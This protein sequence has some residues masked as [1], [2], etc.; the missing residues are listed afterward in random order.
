MGARGGRRSRSC[1]E[2]SILWGNFSPNPAPFLGHV[3]AVT[4]QVPGCRHAAGWHAGECRGAAERPPARGFSWSPLAGP[5]L[6]W[7]SI[8]PFPA[9]TVECKGPA[10][11]GCRR[12]RPRQ[13]CPASPGDVLQMLPLR[14]RKPLML[15]GSGVSGQGERSPPLSGQPHLL[16]APAVKAVFACRALAS[17]PRLDWA[18]GNGPQ[19]SLPSARPLTQRRACWCPLQPAA[20]LVPLTCSALRAAAPPGRLQAQPSSPGPAPRRP[21]GRAPRSHK[22]PARKGCFAAN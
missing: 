9:S 12:R 6:Q 4:P 16:P 7:V 3:L 1:Q 18:P 19:P 15:A 2:N 20:R 22:Q 13:T 17:S 21:R 11:P 5:S 8:P 14:P 10:T